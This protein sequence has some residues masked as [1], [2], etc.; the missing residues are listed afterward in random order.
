MQVREINMKNLKIIL[1]SLFFCVALGHSQDELQEVDVL[2][3]DNQT[4]NDEAT[5]PF[6]NETRV[7]E[8]RADDN[9]KT[10]DGVE[11]VVIDDFE[12]AGIWEGDMPRDHGIIRVMRR[13]GSPK[14]INDAGSQYV[15][16]AKISFF[17]TGFAWA[18]ISPPREKL[19]NGLTRK[20]KL[21]TLGRGFNHELKAV[22]RD[23]VGQLHVISFGRLDYYGWKEMETLMIS[24][25]DNVKQSK[26]SFSGRDGIHLNSIVVDCAMDR[27]TGHY[28]IYFDNLRAEVEPFEPLDE[29]DMRDDW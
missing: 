25:S 15:L 26:R 14:E 2:P 29:D 10:A 18:S 19:I 27:T 9:E 1:F 12:D 23:V 3:N 22:I 24:D 6:L 8:T 7:N 28:Y 11:V 16:G 13:E 20:L 5:T 4:E 21:W 17:K